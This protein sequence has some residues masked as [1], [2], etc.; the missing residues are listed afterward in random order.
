MGNRSTGTTAPSSGPA[1]AWS[2]SLR[3]TRE[4]AVLRR[5]ARADRLPRHARPPTTSRRVGAERR[6]RATGSWTDDFGSPHRRV[7]R[8]D[9]FTKVWIVIDETSTPLPGAQPHR[10]GEKCRPAGWHTRFRRTPSIASRSSS[11]STWGRAERPLWVRGGSPSFRGRRHEWEVR[12]RVTLCRCGALQEQAILRRHASR[13]RVHRPGDAPR[14]ASADV[15]LD[16]VRVAGQRSV[17]IQGRPPVAPAA[18]AAGRR[19]G[20]AGLRSPSVVRAPA[21]R[22][23]LGTPCR[24]SSCSS[25]ASPSIRSITSLSSTA[26]SLPPWT[27]ACG[28]HSA[29]TGRSPGSTDSISGRPG[30]PPGMN[31]FATTAAARRIDPPTTRES[32]NPS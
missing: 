30:A 23:G 28:G 11:P 14:T 6:S 19:A 8:S 25:C 5:L 9:R 21:W 17:G 3:E 7:L 15:A 22:P 18:D 29:A 24:R 20:R 10:H 4:Q 26:P 2:L 32:R 27:P 31:R 1:T 12:N 13:E 16:R